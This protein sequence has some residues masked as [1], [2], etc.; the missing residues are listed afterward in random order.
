MHFDIDFSGKPNNAISFEI[1]CLGVIQIVFKCRFYISISESLIL[2]C[3]QIYMTKY[4]IKRIFLFQVSL[5][6]VFLTN[7]RLQ[8]QLRCK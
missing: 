2:F 1:S 8:D 4:S 5:Q 6:L 3:M 7:A